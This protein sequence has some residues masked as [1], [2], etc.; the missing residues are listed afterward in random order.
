M[1]R[2]AFDEAGGFDEKLKRGED[3]AFCI[4][5]AARSEVYY[6]APVLF[7][8]RRH[9]E[10]STS[11]ANRSGERYKE[12]LLFHEWAL[13]Y[14]RQNPGMEKFTARAEDNYHAALHAAAA[15][16][17]WPISRYVVFRGLGVFPGLR[18][19]RGWRLL[20]DCFL[21]FSFSRRLSAWIS[22][23]IGV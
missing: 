17:P 4:N 21:P 5:A 20:M 1:R 13:R 12:E 7:R 22:R 10:S 2:T 6:Y 15:L 9:P 8:Y 3:I 11:R 19:K 18:A 14:M 16:S 23:R